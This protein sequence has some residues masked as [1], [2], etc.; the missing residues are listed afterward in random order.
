MARGTVTPAAENE[1]GPN[2]SERHLATRQDPLLPLLESTD[3]WVFKSHDRQRRHDAELYMQLE[4][5]VLSV[6]RAC[7]LLC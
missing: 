2:L 6:A 4:A 1:N 3:H 5:V 7:P